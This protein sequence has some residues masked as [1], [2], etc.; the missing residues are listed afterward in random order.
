MVAKVK[1]RHQSVKKQA[2]LSFL[3]GDGKYLKILNTSP[4]F[5][6]N[7]E[8]TIR[9]FEY[10]HSTSFHLCVCWSVVMG[11]VVKIVLSICLSFTVQQ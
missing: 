2:F 8:V 3:I 1:N 11:A 7:T 9:N 4:R 5:E 6:S 10:S